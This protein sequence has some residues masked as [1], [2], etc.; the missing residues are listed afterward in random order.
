MIT[1]KFVSCIGLSPLHVCS[2]KEWGGTGPLEVGQFV[3]LIR[4]VNLSW[5]EES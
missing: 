1:D 5:I 4:M 2:S 3:I